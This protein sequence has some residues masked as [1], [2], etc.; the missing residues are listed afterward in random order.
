MDL[1]LKGKTVVV[2][3]ASSG[4]GR[5]TALTFA[6]EGARVAIT[7]SGSKDRADAVVETIAAAG[8]EALAV[9]LDLADAKTIDSAFAEA[10]TRL[11]PIDVL[12]ANAVAQPEWRSFTDTPLD[13][14]L[15]DV[16]I[17]LEGT[18]RTIAVALP[19]LRAN[20]GRLVIISSGSASEGLPNGTAYLTAKTALEGFARS[21]AWEVGKDGLLVNT[22]APGVTLT[23]PAVGDGQLKRDALAAKIPSGKLSQPED[24]AGLILFLGSFANTNM[25]GEIM[26]EG[27]S[28][29]RSSHIG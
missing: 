19:D 27:S 2:T 3:G 10:R 18:I 16:T 28:N 29:G 22:V 14:W 5:A 13:E 17:N 25:T 23:H 6:A 4:I 9:H 1:G 8:G 24:V 21:L 11:G 15:N 12:I 7:Y 26:R 20:A